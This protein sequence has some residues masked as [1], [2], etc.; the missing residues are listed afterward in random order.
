MDVV[1]YVNELPPSSRLGSLRD[2]LREET[3]ASPVDMYQYS[4]AQILHYGTP[5]RLSESEFLGRFLVIGI[6]SA[7]EAYFRGVLSS[8]IEICPIAQSTASERTIN[9]GGLLWHGQV[10]FSRSA[11][12]HTSFASTRELTQTLKNYLGI[13]LDDRTF[14]DLLDQFETVCHLRHGIVHSDGL[15]PG[16]NAVQ[17]D[18]QRYRKP[19]RITI[20]YE[21]LQA[22][23]A[24]VNT[25]VMTLNRHLFQ[26]M[27]KR[28]AID[29]RRRADWEPSS[30]ARN[31]GFI[32]NIFYC[33]IESK[34][35]SGRAKITKSNCL[36]A[37]K[38]LYN[39]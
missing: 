8:C 30:E 35:R 3:L 32:W 26:E 11:F 20:G 24:V 23:A 1:D 15:L 17:L 28:W 38:A 7:A 36:G 19:V 27:C 6:V 4:I 18:I 39:V 5:K 25:L 21:Q 10:G 37:V 22:V 31:S 13:G 34:R 14:K 33:K 2:Y 29:W 12:D 9:L 16:R